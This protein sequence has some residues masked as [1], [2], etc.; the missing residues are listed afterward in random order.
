M[1]KVKSGSLIVLICFLS[2]C[3]QSNY[4]LK[5]VE[6]SREAM[7]SRW[8][9]YANTEL[10]TLIAS[11]KNR[12]E[13]EMNEPVGIA[14]QTLKKGYPQSLLSN[15]TTDVMQQIAE[16]LWDDVDFSVMNM[17]GMRATLNQGAIT[18]GNLYEVL[19]FENSLVLVELPAKAVKELFE[20]IAFQGGQGMSG[21]VE[22]VVKKRKVESLKIGG[23][24]LDMK[25][26]YRIAT[27]DYV[28]E[29]ND[30][31]VAFQQATQRMDSNKQLRDCM[32]DYVKTLTAN[33]LEVNATIDNRITI[34]N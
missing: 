11:Y 12:L 3:G 29:G 20:F 24:A 6:S 21:T 9:V 26:T 16:Q 2:A 31:M 10:A 15:F 14:A 28:A 33:N 30:G 27:I 17:G 23:K 22:L 13:T 19:P 32:I 25:K 18:I 8:D 4:G 34:H 1:K 5:S 7:D